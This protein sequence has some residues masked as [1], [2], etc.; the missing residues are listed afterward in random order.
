MSSQDKDYYLPLFLLV[1]VMTVFVYFLKTS[2]VVYP[3]PQFLDYNQGSKLINIID[4][5]ESDTIVAV[6]VEKILNQIEIDSYIE[7][8]ELLNTEFNVNDFAIWAGFQ[9][10]GLNQGI[11]RSIS[12]GNIFCRGGFY[13]NI[14]EVIYNLDGEIVGNKTHSENIN[15]NQAINNNSKLD[16]IAKEVCPYS[17]Y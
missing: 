15:T 2:Q 11:Y 8:Y 7:N 6:K 10:V 4:R 9:R 5:F 12:S 13:Q 3:L 14:R 1:L 17:K 16:S